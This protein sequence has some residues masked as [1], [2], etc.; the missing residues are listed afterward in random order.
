MHI[1]LQKYLSQAGVASRRACE[2][3]I[4]QGR[5][6]V[7]GKTVNKLGTKVDPYKD[8]IEVDGSI[9][10]T[11]AYSIYII[12][13]KPKGILT[14]V[15]DPLG[16]PT[17][18]DLLKDVNERVFPVG[19]LDKDTEGLLLLTNDGEVTFRLTHPKYEIVKTYVAQIE[20][21]IGKDD[22]KTLE[23]GVV[24]E[25]GITAPAQVKIVKNL[26]DSTIIEIKIHEGRKRQIRR[27]CR[28]IGHPVMS[29]KR[30][31]IANLSLK[32]LKTG[33]WRLLSPKEIKHITNL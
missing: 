9:C 28:A 26:D 23:K 27:M 1:R 17:V 12:M 30:T 13:N 20:G 7:N 25:D 29:L 22:I 3:I 24:L 15:K 5:V 19:R 33:E 18:I 14:T 32:G 2:N 21:I 31:R 10:H 4:L 8:Q 16:R 11:R 6:K